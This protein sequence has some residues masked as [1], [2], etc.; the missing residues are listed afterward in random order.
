[1]NRSR[2]FSFVVLLPAVLSACAGRSAV[3]SEM[4]RY[5]PPPM[6]HATSS[7]VTPPPLPSIR[8]DS[9]IHP[10]EFDWTALKE[11]G[12][13]ELT[14]PR[15][16]AVFYTPNASRHE[17]LS[18]AFTDDAAC[19]VAL[20]DGF[21]LEALE[22][23]ILGRNPLVSSAG[24][25]VKATLEAYSQAANLEE[26]LRQYGAFTASIMT[27][28]GAMSD[29]ESIERKYP[30][31]GIVSLKGDI[32][33]QEVR[34]ARE[35]FEIAVR[36]AV[37]Q[38]RK[39]YW[40]LI[41]AE[42]AIDITAASL[43]L[44][45]TLE[46]STTRRYETGAGPVQELSAV[47][48]QKQKMKEELTTFE[49]EKLN[50]EAK[51][52]ALL[53]LPATAKIGTPATGKLEKTFPSPEH[54]STLAAERRQELRKMRA[55]ISRM[56]LMIEMAE[57]EIFPGFTGNLSLTD[58]RA[59]TRAGTMRMQEPFS[60]TSEAG[61]GAGIP[62]DSGFG[63]GEAYLRET[64]QKLTA[65]RR[66]LSGEEAL[67][68]SMVQD[69]WLTADRARRQFLLYKDRITAYAQLDF[70]AAAKAVESGGKSFPE[71]IGTATALFETRLAVEKSASDLGRAL[72]E[73]RE[74][75]GVSW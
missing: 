39:A 61:A 59:V 23:L 11:K 22:I 50:S 70:S 29:M 17:A 14:A 57:T 53:L 42:G 47:S 24:H 63:L 9:P 41:F 15:P 18:P 32:V 1:M 71:L 43:S 44:L 54:L 6:F 67:T 21:S 48:V 35:D 56:E 2:L 26:I 45:K 25:T 33:T 60:V 75:T 68:A 5:E 74:I 38:A 4:D 62:R 72:A 3:I 52:R 31:P 58:N 13:K 10:P 49:T 30:F 27:G 19:E 28:V 65:L 12:E 20:K 8:P 66:E 37:T 69:A 40:D 34:I 46:S 64:K 73:L 36:S 55:M 7:A 51:I 16:D